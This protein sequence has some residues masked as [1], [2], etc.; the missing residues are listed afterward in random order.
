MQ[1][2]LVFCAVAL[3]FVSD[4]L[5]MTPAC[6]WWSDYHAHIYVYSLLFWQ[7]FVYSIALPIVV[8]IRQSAMD[9]LVGS[10]IFIVRPDG[11]R[12]SIGAHWIWTGVEREKLVFRFWKYLSWCIRHLHV[13]GDDSMS[14]T[15]RNLTVLS[16]AKVHNYYRRDRSGTAAG[17]QNVGIPT[18]P[19]C[20]RDRSRRRRDHLTCKFIGAG[21]R[22]PFGNYNNI[23]GG[24]RWCFGGCEDFSE[25]VLST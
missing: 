5:H 4:A 18:I 9:A 10:V 15:A 2:E 19:G 7:D 21:P 14:H 22:T 1:G 8:Y 24:V 16:C 3:H 23:P 20:R 17:P 6:S 12:I 25:D 13:H 11:V